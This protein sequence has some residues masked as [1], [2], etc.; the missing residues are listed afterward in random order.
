MNKIINTIR[1]LELLPHRGDMTVSILD[2]T[3]KS[4]HYGSIRVGEGKTGLRRLANTG[5]GIILLNP[6]PALFLVYCYVIVI[7]L[8]CVLRCLEEVFL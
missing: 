6:S 4:G 5:R 7:G 2:P 3:P 8:A 1:N